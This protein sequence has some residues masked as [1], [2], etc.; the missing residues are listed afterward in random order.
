M[1][2]WALAYLG[3][4][5]LGSFIGAWITVQRWT[6]GWPFNKKAGVDR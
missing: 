3:A 2:W 4:L 1:N 6:E 5:V